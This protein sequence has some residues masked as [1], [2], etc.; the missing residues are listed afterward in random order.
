MY[1]LFFLGALNGYTSL[2]DINSYLSQYEKEIR[3][4]DQVETVATSML[5]IMARGPFTSLCLVSM[6]RIIRYTNIGSI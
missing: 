5:A 4:E 2:G 1:V 3:N 6:H